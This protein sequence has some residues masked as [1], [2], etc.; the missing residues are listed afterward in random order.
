[1][2]KVSVIATLIGMAFANIALVVVI[3]ITWNIS[4]FSKPAILSLHILALFANLV[5]SHL[6]LG[7]SPLQGREGK[8]NLYL[9][10]QH[11]KQQVLPWILTLPT[12]PEVVSTYLYIYTC[13]FICML[14]DFTNIHVLL[15]YFIMYFIIDHLH[16]TSAL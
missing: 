10:R 14:T 1:M 7:Y 3:A 9:H 8:H 6:L 11:S 15:L 5:S 13:M 4:E 12:C 2:T 16:C